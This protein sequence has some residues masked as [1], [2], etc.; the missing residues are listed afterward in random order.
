MNDGESLGCH[1]NSAD[2]AIFH[3]GLNRVAEIHKGEFLSGSIIAAESPGVGFTLGAVPH[4]EIRIAVSKSPLTSQLLGGLSSSELPAPPILPEATLADE[5]ILFCT[6]GGVLGGLVQV[7]VKI[8]SSELWWKF[9]QC[10][11]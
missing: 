11:R 9:I 2:D 8:S 5:L 1:L 3:A 6:I 7:A 10:Q 4:D